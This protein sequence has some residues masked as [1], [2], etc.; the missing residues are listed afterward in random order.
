MMKIDDDVVDPKPGQVLCDVTN[1][2]LTKNWNGGFG[3]VF[4]QG[5]ESCAVTGG[6][7][8]CTHNQNYRT[9][10][11][12]RTYTTKNFLQEALDASRITR[13]N[14]PGATLRK[15][16]LRLSETATLMVGF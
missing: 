10:T 5:P 11:T 13:S 9:C 8:H 1:K 15:R 14:V 12:Y 3:A 7:N 16:V 4:C 6:K 2:R